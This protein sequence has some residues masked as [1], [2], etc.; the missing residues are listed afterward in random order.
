MAVQDVPCWL[1]AGLEKQEMIQVDP[2]M[3]LDGKDVP[4]LDDFDALLHEAQ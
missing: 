2:Q 1:L 4:G 3:A